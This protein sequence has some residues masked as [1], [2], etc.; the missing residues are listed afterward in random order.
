MPTG[1]L[2]PRRGHV[3]NMASECPPLPRHLDRTRPQPGRL[4]C[5]SG[6][7]G[8][9]LGSG[10]WNAARS[11]EPGAE[12]RPPPATGVAAWASPRLR[13]LL[14]VRP[15]ARPSSNP[16]EKKASFRQ[17]GGTGSVGRW[18]DSVHQD[19]RGRRGPRGGTW[20]GRNPGRRRN[21]GGLKG[22]WEGRK[23]KG[24]GGPALPDQAL[25][26][27]FFGSPRTDLEDQDSSS[28]PCL[29]P[30]LS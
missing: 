15:L 22:T 21:V 12:P 17:P 23:E 28:S 19:P 7:V 5:R 27:F 25:F 2:G 11:P 20:P 9:G 10:V 8:A 16:R 3:G 6:D 14:R 24:E 26:F 4:L 18:S 29:G 30:S 13:C 1:T